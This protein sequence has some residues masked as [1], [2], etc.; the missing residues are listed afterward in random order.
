MCTSLSLDFFESNMSTIFKDNSKIHQNL[1]IDDFSTNSS[2]F[3]QKDH[4]TLLNLLF[5]C[6]NL[7][8]N[9]FMKSTLI[10]FIYPLLVI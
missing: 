5:V 4:N 1:P 6:K 9:V 7:N 8:T 3:F 10:K 2:L